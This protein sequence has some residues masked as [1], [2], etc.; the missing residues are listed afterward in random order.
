MKPNEGSDAR[1]RLSTP[2][3]VVSHGYEPIYERGFCNGLS[4]A[5]ID[6]VL[7]SSDQTDYAGLRQGTRTVN[8]RGS[9]SRSRPKWKKILNLVRYHLALIVHVIRHRRA[10]IHVVGLL[11]P[12]FLCGV[13]EGL[14][15]RALS[16]R[17]VVTVHNLLPHD[18][19]T[20]WNRLVFGLSY[21][22]ASTLVVHTRRVK[23]QLIEIQGVRS[24]RVVVM[25]HGLE[26]IDESASRQCI[27]FPEGP[28]HL[29]FF[30][31]V[32]RYKGVDVLLHALADLPGEVRLT[33]A[34]ACGDRALAREIEHLVDVHPKRD[35]I[36]WID[37]YV[38]EVEIKP[39][40]LSAHA[41]VLPYRRI[42]QSGVLFQGIR[43]GV[44]LIVTDV[45]SLAD[46]ARQ[47][48]GEVALADDPL[49]LRAAIIRLAE[50]RAARKRTDILTLANKYDWGRTTKVLRSVYDPDGMA[51]DER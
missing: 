15:F 20:N 12:A 5:G 43:F 1:S 45:G 41:L 19:E 31:K 49:D 8:L 50:R 42:E 25:E 51:N 9:Q 34:G 23:E 39:L 32:M 6:F 35:N 40:F 33:I 28:L 16:R 10:C 2:T 18:R 7:I 11:E 14:V 47:F 26:P 4:D 27:D 24:D 46:Y 30:G 3:V 37:R 44:P 13:V 21:R 38:E 48:G 17:Y 22:L 29:L 36:T